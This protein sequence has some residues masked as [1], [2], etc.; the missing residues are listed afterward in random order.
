MPLWSSSMALQKGSPLTNFL[1][2]VIG[3]VTEKGQIKQII[4]KYHGQVYEHFCQPIGTSSR[5]ASLN[6]LMLLFIIVSSGMILA[7]VILLF[8]SCI[9]IFYG[10]VNTKR[11]LSNVVPFSLENK[12]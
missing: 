11:N 1:K 3:E 9:S 5:S 8:E 4:T 10:K 6:T 2:A 7:I 12:S